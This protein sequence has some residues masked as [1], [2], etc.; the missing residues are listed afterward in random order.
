[1]TVEEATEEILQGAF[2][3]CEHCKSDPGG[4]RIHDEISICYYCKGHAQVY[5]KKYLLACRTLGKEPIPIPKSPFQL[6][7]EEVWTHM[8]EK[9]GILQE[10]MKKQ[11]F[12]STTQL[13]KNWSTPNSRSVSKGWKGN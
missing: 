4:M 12:S 9:A 10:D 11:R 3:P 6:Q 2:E 7:E 5:R 8:F 1:M 13:S